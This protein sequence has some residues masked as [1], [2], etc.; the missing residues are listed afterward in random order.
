MRKLRA[1]DVKHTIPDGGPNT[2]GRAAV[3]SFGRG[4]TRFAEEFPAVTSLV[5]LIGRAEE[6]QTLHLQ[7][8]FQGFEKQLNF[9]AVLVDGGNGGG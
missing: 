8:L 3:S 7:V 6:F 1:Q 2:P 4:L 9:P 5:E